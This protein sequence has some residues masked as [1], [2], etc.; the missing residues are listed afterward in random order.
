[1][2][3]HACV[4]TSQE[5]RPASQLSLYFVTELISSEE[6]QTDN[7]FEN[8]EEVK[9]AMLDLHIIETLEKVSKEEIQ[10]QDDHEPQV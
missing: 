8:P 3:L 10:F 1:M 4:I 7:M 6:R 5:T 2:Q 9:K